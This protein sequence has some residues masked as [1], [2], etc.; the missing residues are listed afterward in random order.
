ME[1]R[2]NVRFLESNL[3]RQLAWINAAD[4]KISFVFA[5]DTAMLGLLAAIS[6][7]K[8]G[9][10]TV[11]PAVLAAV[12][13]VLVLISLILLS[14]ASFPRTKGPKS[15]VVYFGS[16][17]QMDVDQFKESVFEMSIESYVDDLCAQ[18]HRNAKI[19]QRK[20]SWVQRASVALYLSV[21]PWSLSI[22]ML[23][24]IGD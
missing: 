17:S 3:A 4:S 24:M 22:Y 6:P 7:A 21:V 18:C 16:I 5:I 11:V 23:Y 8:V 9:D 12:A 13:A 1:D 2:E 20:Y 14:L 19:S 15:S 10:W